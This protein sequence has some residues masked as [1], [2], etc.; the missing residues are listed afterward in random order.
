MTMLESYIDQVRKLPL[1]DRSR[2]YL[3]YM[4]IRMY[5]L[6][7]GA[8]YATISEALNRNEG[9]INSW[10]LRDNWT[11]KFDEYCYRMVEIHMETLKQ[12]YVKATA[13]YTVKHL[14]AANKI[15]DHVLRKT[16]QTKDLSVREALTLSSALK[17]CTESMLPFL[18]LFDRVTSE[19]PTP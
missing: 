15:A 18:E 17:N 1:P 8:V 13:R 16:K 14:K 9:I 5:N 3:L 4:Y 10:A 6:A 12:S 2:A 7:E 11:T 19:P